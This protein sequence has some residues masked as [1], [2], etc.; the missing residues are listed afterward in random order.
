MRSATVAA[1]G[2]G[3]LPALVMALFFLAEAVRTPDRTWPVAAFA[4][5]AL[6][7]AGVGVLASAAGLAL[8]RGPVAVL[9]ASALLALTVP[10]GLG[11]LWTIPLA[12]TL[13]VLLAVRPLVGLDGASLVA[14]RV[15]GAVAGASALLI[16]G[17]S[18]PLALEEG[19]EGS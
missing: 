4:I 12:L 5:V 16:L 18:V 15:L 3:L 9:G 13:P 19:L 14:A 10:L 17:L 7:L 2:I 6:V 1:W 11:I 8:R